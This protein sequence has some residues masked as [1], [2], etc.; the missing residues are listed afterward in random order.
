MEQPLGFVIKGE[1]GVRVCKLNKIIYRLKQSPKA[2]FDKSSP[3]LLSFS[4]KRWNFDN[5]VFVL[6]RNKHGST[7]YIHGW[8]YCLWWCYKYWRSEGLL[9]KNLLD[10]GS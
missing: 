6:K 2:W 8:Y 1:S 3:I 9:E 4:F 7:D 10:K 5:S